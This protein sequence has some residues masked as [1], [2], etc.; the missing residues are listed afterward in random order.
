MDESI[1]QPKKSRGWPK[2]KPRGP[3]KAPTPPAMFADAP[4][5]SAPINVRVLLKNGFEST[6]GCARRSVE[7]GFHV[8]FYPSEMDRYRETRREFALSEIVEIEIT[9]ARQTY[10]PTPIQY[11]VDEPVLA[12]AQAAVVA[13]TGPKI[14][15]VRKNASSIIGQLENSS[16]PIKMN[17]LPNLS[18]GDSEA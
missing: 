17:A 6:F 3:R 1:E 13:S 9:E 12:R 16:G 8:F 15:S 4:E 5:P 11:E 2:G 14:H 18:F 7:N 10:Q